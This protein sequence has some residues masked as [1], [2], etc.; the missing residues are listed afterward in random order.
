M[1]FT[2]FDECIDQ[3]ENYLHSHDRSNNTINSYRRDLRLFNKWFHLHNGE[4]ALPPNITPIDV[5]EYKEQLQTVDNQKPASINRKLASLSVFCKWAMEEELITSNPAENIRE[6]KHSEPLIRWLDKKEQ[7][8]LLRAVQKDGSTRDITIILLLLNTGL[9]VSELSH[10]R[11]SDIEISDRK[12]KLVVREGKG[13]RYR[14]VSLNSDARQA[15]VTLFEKNLANSEQQY[16]FSGQKGERLKPWGIQDV[17]RRYSYLARIDNVTPH[18]LRHTFGKNLADAGVP[19]DQ[20]AV[21]MGHSNIETTRRYIKPS[22]KDLQ[23]AVAKIELLN[24]GNN[25]L[26]CIQ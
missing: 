12:G 26:L 3:F 7:Y 19:I 5:R 24:L 13:K 10:L 11:V 4:E 25:K 1:Q 17:L 16:L 2:T 20:I 14:E 23:E 22:E 9:R 6:V 18:S 8:A 21:L 15:I